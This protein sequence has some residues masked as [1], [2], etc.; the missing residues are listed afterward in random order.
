MPDR[1]I[2]N[3][4]VAA[5]RQQRRRKFARDVIT[6]IAR[7]VSLNGISVELLQL[8][9]CPLFQ[10]CV[11][12]LCSLGEHIT[13]G[14]NGSKLD[15]FRFSILPMHGGT[16]ACRK[17]GLAER[18]RSASLLEALIR[19]PRPA[20]NRLE[21]AI[22]ALGLTVLA[23]RKM[24]RVLALTD[25]PC[26]EAFSNFKL[27]II[28]EALQGG[29]LTT[30]KVTLPNIGRVIGEI[31]TLSAWVAWF[32][33]D[34]P[35]CPPPR[36]VVLRSVPLSPEGYPILMWMGGSLKA[37][38]R[39]WDI[40]PSKEKVWDLA[41]MRTFGRGLPAGDREKVLNSFEEF[42]GTITKDQHLPDMVRYGLGDAAEVLGE[43]LLTNGPKISG[44][45]HTSFGM[46]KSFAE[47]V[48]W[49]NARINRTQA[50]I[51]SE[52]FPKWATLRVIDEWPSAE[53]LPR[54]AIY[55]IFNRIFICDDVLEELRTNFDD[56]SKLY[57]VDV[58]YVENILMSD[59]RLSLHLLEPTLFQLLGNDLDGHV[60]SWVRGAL[61]D[62]LIACASHHVRD[63]L[64]TS[65]E[66]KGKNLLYFSE[67]NDSE[68]T[69]CTYNNAYVTTLSEDGWKGRTITVF[70]VWYI[71]LQ[72][73]LRFAWDPVYNRLPNF[74]IGNHS[75]NPIWTFLN[76]R[77]GTAGV[78]H[79]EVR[80][81]DLYSS[82]TDQSAATDNFVAGVVSEFWDRFL[83]GARIPCSDPMSY[84]VRMFISPTE[85]RPGPGFEEKFLEIVGEDSLIVTPRCF[86][87]APMSF[88]TLTGVSFCVIAIADYFV[89]MGRDWDSFD[90]REF[91]EHMRTMDFAWFG[92]VGDDILRVKNRAFYFKLREVMTD[93]GLVLSQGKD[94]GSSHVAILCED[95]AW[96][97]HM[98][99]RLEYLDVIKYRLLVKGGS[100]SYTSDD[101]LVGKT[102]ALANQLRPKYI[103]EWPEGPRTWYP[104]IVRAIL[105]YNLIQTNGWRTTVLGMLTWMPASMGGLE[106][107]FKPWEVISAE[108]QELLNFL[109]YLMSVPKVLAIS[110]LWD[111]TGGASPCKRGIVPKAAKHFSDKVL[112]LLEIEQPDSDS[113]HPI[114]IRGVSRMVGQLLISDYDTEAMYHIC[115]YSGK[116]RVKYPTLTR[117]A[118]EIGYVELYDFSRKVEGFSTLVDLLANKNV[119]KSGRSL[120]SGLNTLANRVEGQLAQYTVSEPH[121]FKSPGDVARKMA[122]LLKTTYISLEQ[123]EKYQST[124]FPTLTSDMH[125]D[126]VRLSD[127]KLDQILGQMYGPGIPESIQE[128]LLTRWQRVK[129]RGFGM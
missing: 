14:P 73:A 48:L 38:Q 119:K 12:N 8:I 55:D 31:K 19:C 92:V 40:P 57:I 113:F 7:D 1:P 64:E 15:K 98:T 106:F 79:G 20:W 46:S 2:R 123:M 80:S 77:D 126:P 107:A 26:L 99:S 25:A 96:I 86:M 28:L 108:N 122:L 114:I 30:D 18:L 51:V 93:L 9:S 62:H 109:W 120:Y 94:L 21:Q 87:G 76:E 115:P 49:S 33:A 24:T 70:T 95:H 61:G 102:R 16:R 66:K 105:G 110:V 111:L 103:R 4:R 100:S 29:T 39:P 43:I 45:T 65:G 23:H 116:R 104:E 41:Q 72:R 125:G 63:S 97:N 118:A 67:V 60:P 35:D 58:C 68:I 32:M 54:H 10:T 121:Q 5:A 6:S 88:P 128:L 83:Q 50:S 84:L 75:E 47:E 85:L 91:R 34:E 56:L 78:Y 17:S 13:I 37:Y 44:R 27:S 52:E 69:S 89:V 81:A 42:F 74:R 101:P 59:G 36:P 124:C 3:D 117:A 127:R 22:T 53:D 112:E 90:A 129:H 11:G 71:I 82:N